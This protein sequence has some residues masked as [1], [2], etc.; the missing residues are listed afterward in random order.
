MVENLSTGT[1]K[2]SMRIRRVP[3]YSIVFC[4]ENIVTCSMRV[5]LDGGLKIEFN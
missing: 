3:F 1:G 4:N 2:N 5:T